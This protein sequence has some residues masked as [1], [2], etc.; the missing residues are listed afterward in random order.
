VFSIVVASAVAL[1]KLELGDRLEI[2]GATGGA[3]ELD[4]FAS[5]TSPSAR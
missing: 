5:V 4:Q 3:F 1:Q 2:F